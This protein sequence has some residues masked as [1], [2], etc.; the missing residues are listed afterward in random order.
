[1]ILYQTI[2]DHYL[3]SIERGTILP[4]EKLPSLRETSNLFD[5]SLST[6]V[7]AY[8]RLELYGYASVR[9][10]SGYFARLPTLHDEVMAVSSD[11]KSKVSNLAHLDELLS[12]FDQSQNKEVAPFGIGSPDSSQTPYRMLNRNLKM[13]LKHEPEA[14]GLYLFGQGLLE[15]RQELSRWIR[16]WVGMN[17]PNQILITNGC[18]EAI[19]I[20]L[21]AECEP[22]DLVAIESPCYFGLLQAIQN[23]KLRALEIK[24]DPSE[25]INP[26]ALE[27]MA[28][29]HRIK[30]LITSANG[31]NPLGF[32]MSDERKKEVLRICEKY[33]IRLIEDDLYGELCF[34]KTRPKSYKYFDKNSIV[35]YCSSFSK[36]LAPGVRIGWCLPAQRTEK[37]VRHKL[38]LNLST[39]SVPQYLFY[40]VLKNEDL[41]QVARNLSSYY[42][43]NLQIYSSIIQ[44][45]L[46]GKVHMTKP[47]GSF[48]IW[49]KVDGLKSMSAFERARRHKISFMPGPLLSATRQFENYV[50][51]NCARAC[52][53]T[54]N[55]QLHKL[56]HLLKN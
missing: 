29:S 44:N 16:P 18:L 51:I 6:T 13:A 24:T 37:Y 11:F 45:Q 1:M 28:K 22:Q 53:E 50:R 33:Q 15:L 19:N 38:S 35:T 25:G 40:H 48:F 36:F 23:H 41:N 5:V 31:Q 4:G 17:S 3:K 55:Q 47:T 34:S 12:L 10:R 32:T 14:Q 39:A 27:A 2:V 52:T 46:E 7:E 9:D 30:A 8:R 54:T 49:M 56:C 43:N 26:A 42:Q 21:S 20:A